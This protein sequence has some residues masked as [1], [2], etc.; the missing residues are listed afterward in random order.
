MNQ[1]D[2]S[3]IQ[4][5]IRRTILRMKSERTI[6]CSFENLKQLVRP[7]GLTCSKSEFENVF[8]SLSRSTARSLNF[9]LYD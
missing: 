2:L 3:E 1:K 7:S 4:S 9:E 6:G 5:T 8:Y